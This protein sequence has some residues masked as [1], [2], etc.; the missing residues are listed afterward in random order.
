M[1]CAM[2]AP[3][4]E[5]HPR[6]PAS[7]VSV[8]VPLYNE[9][10][11]LPELYRR[12]CAVLD[13]RPFELVLVDDGSCDRTP[14]M[15]RELADSDARVRVLVLSRNFG[16]QAALTAGLEH[17]R[18]DAV[19]SLDGDLQDPPEVIPRMLAEWEEGY[20]V[21]VGVRHERPGEPRWRLW[22]IRTFYRLF[23]KIAQ[24]DAYEGNAGDFR[25]FDRR[26]LDALNALPE[27]NRYVRG[28]STWVGFRHTVVAYERDVRFA[29]ESK[30]PLRGL[31]GLAANGVLSFS[32]VPLRLSAGI[33]LTFS[34]LALLAIPVII[35]LKLLGVYEVPGTA[36]I[37]ILVLFVG[38]IQL[39]TLGIIGEY[40][41]RTY[42]EVKRRPAYL[43]ASDGSARPQPSGSGSSS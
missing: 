21:I 24:L 40:L 30:Y 32:I 27:R 17:A 3:M 20:D 33:G 23:A 36:S 38:G 19:V 31:L 18:G 10:E 29:G 22:A 34:V 42:D 13:D 25:L 4:D 6:P 39:V 11:T 35:L 16:H 43:L 28:L 14:S 15:L 7:L 1:M 2:S 37:H 26:A 9:E 8:V 41:G 12:L 5:P